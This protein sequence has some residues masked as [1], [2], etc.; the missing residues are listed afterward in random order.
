MLSTGGS[1]DSV[2]SGQK[3]RT[4]LID[5]LYAKPPLKRFTND[6][7]S[8][9]FPSFSAFTILLI[10]ATP[11]TM[12]C[13]SYRVHEQMFDC[14]GHSTTRTD[15]T[16]SHCYGWELQL[17][18][19]ARHGHRHRHTQNWWLQFME[20]HGLVTKLKAGVALGCLTI[21]P[22]GLWGPSHG[23]S[24]C[25]V[26]WSSLGDC[27]LRSWSKCLHFHLYLVNVGM[28]RYHFMKNVKW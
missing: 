28:E 9:N 14:F 15:F 6:L 12:P 16:V 24:S 21:E 1:H 22:R 3:Q 2:R 10:K 8:L 20:T 7:K 23:T 27:C 11:D 19:P 17:L 5:L 4:D 25:D 18:A 13:M 26:H